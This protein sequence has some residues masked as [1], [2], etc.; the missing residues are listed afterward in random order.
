VETKLQPGSGISHYRIISRLGIGGM[1]EVYLA[2]DTTLDRKVALKILPAEI[3]AN[4][5]R[6]RRFVQEAKAAAALNHPHIAH[7]YEIGEAEGTHFISMEHVDGETLREKIHRGQTSMPKLLKY[8]AQ[9]AEGLAKA[10]AAGI[11]HRDLKPDNIMVTR[12]GYA[13][14]LD[15][16]LVKLIEPQEGIGSGAEGPIDDVTLVRYDYSTPGTIIGTIGYM[17]PEQ[18]L[19]KSKE[20]DHRSD[21]FSLGCILYE[22]AEGHKAFEGKDALDSLH[23]IVHGPTPVISG[24]DAFPPE[25]LQRIVRRCLAKD[26]ENRYQSSHDVAIELEELRQE[27][28]GTTDSSHSGSRPLSGTSGIKSGGGGDIGSARKSAAGA[29]GTAPLRSTSNAEYIASEIKRHRK[30]AA[31]LALLAIVITVVGLRYYFHSQ[32]ALD[33]IAVLPFTNM[34]GDVDMEYLSD[35]ISESLINNIS[36]LPS[37]KVIARSSSFRY[38]G[39]DA[40]PQ[41]VANALGVKTILSGRV[42]KRG[43][44]LVIS[45]ELVNAR[46]K[47][48]VWGEQY[49]RKSADLLEVQSEISGEIADKLRLR[50]SSGE[51]QQ[52]AKRGTVNPQA[53]ELLLK[54]LFFR[55]KGGTENSEKAIEYYKEAIAVDPAYALAYADLSSTYRDL[56]A[57]SV[58]DPKE[59]IP[60]AEEAARKS[61]ELDANLADAHLA[62]ALA[63][64]D[65]WDWANAEREY[66]RAIE[67]TPNL[68]EAHLRYAFYLSVVGRH[69]EAITEIERARDFDPLSPAVNANVGY[70]LYLARKYDQAIQSLQK[71]LE[72]DRSF[73]PTYNVLGFTYAANGMQAKAIAAFQQATNLGNKSPSL[74]IH[75]GAAYAQAGETEQARAILHQLLAN[76]NNVSAAELAILYGALNDHEQAFAS[77]EKAYAAHDPNLQYLGVDPEFDSLRSDARFANLTRRIGL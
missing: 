56:A 50:L 54:G 58:L 77:L 46:D 51:R 12:D 20:V 49:N 8:L 60:R 38:K 69:Q 15:F 31:I 66:R 30:G 48:Q 10:H 75:L 17:S 18:A 73:P 64:R 65:A 25:E 5:D 61:L 34:T 53:Y 55:H 47:T 33:S 26:P 1:G 4:Q 72:L 11:V 40:D 62:M 59:F 76:E 36:Q 32:L 63:N 35:G 19:G 7:I 9:V 6:M 2:Q 27:L 43:D 42:M 45:V 24:S 23:K 57:G 28:S 37:V 29:S 13:K 21:I 41:E 71:T 16:G 3:A 14:I 68:A 67:L 70:V 74:Q 22:A 39:K 44:N 52:L